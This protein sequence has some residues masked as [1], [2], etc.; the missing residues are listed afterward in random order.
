[1]ADCAAAPALFYANLVLPLGATYKNTAAYLSRLLERTSFAR[2]VKE[3]EPYLA[4]FPG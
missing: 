2:V 3:A 1:M 4:M